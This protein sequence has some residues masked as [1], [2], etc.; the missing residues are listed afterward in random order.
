M[1]IKF[2]ATHKVQQGD[3]KGPVYEKD[4][5]HDFKGPVAETYAQK[6][7]RRGWAVEVASDVKP[8][9]KGGRGGRNRKPDI[10]PV[11]VERRVNGDGFDLFVMKEWPQRTQIAAELLK[12]PL[13]GMAVD[14]G[15]VTVTVKNGTAVYRA[16]TEQPNADHLV[17]ELLDQIYEA[18]PAASEPPLL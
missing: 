3:G 18:A 8:E 11:Q 10:E 15:T 2:I 17:F 12:Q 4:S 5:L 1:K 16:E 7:V 9:G 14:G 6:Y 13:E